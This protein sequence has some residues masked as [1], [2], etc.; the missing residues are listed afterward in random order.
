[1]FRKIMKYKNFTWE[2]VKAILLEGNWSNT[3]VVLLWWV[4]H[5][6]NCSLISN[7]LKLTEHT[8]L[9][10]MLFLLLP[11]CSQV[12]WG[13]VIS[14]VTLIENKVRMEQNAGLLCALWWTVNA[15]QKSKMPP[16]PNLFL[17][18]LPTWQKFRCL[19][20]ALSQWRPGMYRRDCK[21]HWVKM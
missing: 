8:A 18:A 10:N 9:M 7:V 17:H 21:E 19:A 14:L 4:M 2:G 11:S 15:F 3:W 20:V 5:M 13:S 6:D 12:I 1:M 16:W